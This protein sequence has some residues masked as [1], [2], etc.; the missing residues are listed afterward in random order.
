MLPETRL[1]LHR[2]IISIRGSTE[3]NPSRGEN[4][5]RGSE[6]GLERPG[7]R[8]WGSG[9]ARTC[10]GLLF[11]LPFDAFHRCQ[12]MCSRNQNQQGGSTW[13]QGRT[14]ACR[15]GRG[16]RQARAGTCCD[17]LQLL[18]CLAPLLSMQSS[19]RGDGLRVLGNA[20]GCQL[21]RDPRFDPRFGANLLPVASASAPHRENSDKHCALWPGPSTQS[22][23]EGR[24]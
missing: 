10:S 15:K 6:A 1:S 19:A 7:R 16:E 8:C 13:L 18:R 24:V 5:S 12:E 3:T 14:R 22:T 11:L 17:F 20:A 4:N 2:P 23:I 21:P 9:E